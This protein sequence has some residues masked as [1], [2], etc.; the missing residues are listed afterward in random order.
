ME[1]FNNLLTKAEHISK[2]IQDSR[3]SKVPKISVP[4]PEIKDSSS[5]ENQG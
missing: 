3:V 4:I 2:L 1:L 5:E